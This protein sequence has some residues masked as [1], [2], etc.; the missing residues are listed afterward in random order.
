M[1]WVLSQWWGEK[2]GKSRPGSR[3]GYNFSYFVSKLKTPA[4]EV[5]T[6]PPWTSLGTS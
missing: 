3:A 4:R 2:P 5:P 1:V 6:R